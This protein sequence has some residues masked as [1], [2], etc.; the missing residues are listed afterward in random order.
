MAAFAEAVRGTLPVSYVL[1]PWRVQQETETRPFHQWLMP[2][3]SVWALFYR[4]GSSYL[5]RF[6][7][8]ADFELAADG[9][10]VEGYPANGVSDGTVNHL[11]L[12]QVVAL[13]LSRQM[14]LVL[15]GSAVEVGATAI[16]FLGHSGRGKSTLAASFATHGM[17]FITDDGLLLRE[18]ETGGYL[19]QPSHPSI[20]LWD[21]SRQ[22]VLPAATSVA[23]AVDYTPKLRMLAGAEVPFCP[24]PRPLRQIF[25]LGTVETD[26]IC[27]S[28][29]SARDAVIEAARNCFLLDVDEQTALKHHYQ[30]L[31]ALA[32]RVP[33]FRLDFPRRF[34]RLDEVR[35]AIICRSQPA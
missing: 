16:A 30:Q 6:P 29:I 11:Y 15:H 18:S 35:R 2:G 17:R 4:R 3:G 28:P 21:D 14:Q 34:D 9:H 8:L 33:F 13:A 10:A 7:G 25:V 5:I 24:E 32:S 23:P 22:A 1:Q 31:L 12:N 20:R 26:T 27:I 19:I